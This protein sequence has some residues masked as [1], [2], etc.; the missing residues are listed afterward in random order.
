MDVH[1]RGFLGFSTVEEWDPAR[2]AETVTT[3][4]NRTAE[5]SIYPYAFLPKTIQRAVVI[6][7][8]KT[9]ARITRTEVQSQ[10]DHL[11]GGK[12]YFVHPVSW[13]SLEWEEDVTIDLADELELHLGGIDGADEH[14]A[15]RVR[16]GSS[17]HDAFGNVL[18]EKSTT[19]HGVD[20]ATVST[21]EIREHDWLVGL[22]ESRSTTSSTPGSGSTPTPRHVGYQYD[23]RGLVCH[24]YLEKDDPDPAIP[25]VITYARDAEGL[26]VG[27]TAS[28][29][30]VPQRTTHVAY[31]PGERV[32]QSQIWNDLG[33][34]QW[35]LRDPALG[36]LLVA[37][38]TN[39][40]RAQARYDDL[41]R[42]VDM[43]PEG[44]D[45][46][47]IDYAPRVGEGGT[48]V[49]LSV[50]TS[51]GSGE[52]RRVD[53]DELSRPI[54]H[55]H[56][57]FDGTWIEEATRYDLLGR[58]AQQTRPGLGEPSKVVTTF[59]YDRLD[60]L[61]QEVRPGNAVSAFVHS[62]LETHTTDPMLHQSYVVRDLDGR[63]I[64]STQIFGGEKLATTYQYGDF[65][66]V[67]RVT[68]LQ[69]NTIVS[70]YDRRGRRWYSDDPDAGTT[71]FEYN[72]LGDLKSKV[73]EGFAATTYKLDFLGRIEEIEDDDGITLLTWDSS[74]HGVGRLAHTLSPDGITQDFTYDDLGRPSTQT[75]TV[76]GSPLSFGVTYDA[77]GRLDTQSY[78]AVPGKPAFTVARH[79][80]P[81]GT[82]DAVHDT[83]SPPQEF[84][85]GS[86][87][88]ADG[89]LLQATL[90]NGLVQQRT[91]SEE[92]GRLV[93][94]SDG[95]AQSL[96][97]DYDFDGQVQ[98]KHDVLANRVEAFVYDELHRLSSWTLGTVIPGP[99]GF[100]DAM[101]TL[102]QTTYSYDDLGNLTDSHRD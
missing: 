99:P 94:L 69:G 96:T 89:R 102:H 55:G 8:S 97:Y 91:Y 48:V 47:T 27:V 15:L 30:K 38:D 12:T 72:G 53:F 1:G 50:T 39:G 18:E 77:L 14:T 16:H 33:H 81:T 43:V 62:F 3:Y 95:K 2:L 60:R 19:I 57:S 21:Y 49:G 92:T 54:G 66:Q 93:S 9:R 13:K 42:V 100:P 90:G 17:T 28:A 76:D 80:L 68:D 5:G 85:H 101:P 32:H 56:T 78:P 46:V 82:L 11:N 65:G 10:I 73:V 6:D 61:T 87:W 36:V 7:G 70:G 40:V 86:D 84:W 75:W 64:E 22:L 4:D 52:Q 34:S 44:G 41:G 58:T 29:F 20:S 88:N 67:A 79:Y 71:V 45:H 31:E 83:A 25:A 98:H 26:I 59:Q 35:F 51:R 63:V 24:V 23:F 74:P 37:E